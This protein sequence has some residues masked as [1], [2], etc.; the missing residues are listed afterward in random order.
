MVLITRT[1]NVLYALWRRWIKSLRPG[2]SFKRYRSGLESL[3]RS[4]CS[5]SS[6]NRERIESSRLRKRSL[7]ARTL[8]QCSGALPTSSNTSRCSTVGTRDS[9]KVTRPR[10]NMP[11]CF[12][13]CDSPSHPAP[14]VPIV[15]FSFFTMLFGRV[16][17]RPAITRATP[18]PPYYSPTANR[19]L[20]GAAVGEPPSYL[21]VS[22]ISGRSSEVF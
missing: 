17:Q 18:V 21:R 6:F 12:A 5:Q 1:L 4:P 16:E 7:T 2:S 3:S 19:S 20:P 10:S 22:I 13:P 8:H 15:T 14:T 9:R 11:S